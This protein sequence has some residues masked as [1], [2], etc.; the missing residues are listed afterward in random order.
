MRTVKVKPVNGGRMPTKGSKFSIGF[1]LYANLGEGG[2][3]LVEPGKDVLVG[4]GISIQPPFDIGGL[5]IGRSSLNS[6]NFLLSVAAIDPD[7]TGEI[8][9][10]LRNETDEVVMVC[11]GERVGQ[12]VFFEVPQIEL[13]Q[14][15]ELEKTDR[16]EG[17]FGSTGR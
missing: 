9:C 11:H 16:G 6:D 15:D 1:D 8:K 17:G 7:Y 4:T 12:I 10:H 2:Y 13:V 5:L 14:V 3:L